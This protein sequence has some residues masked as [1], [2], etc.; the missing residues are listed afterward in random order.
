MQVIRRFND[1]YFPIPAALICGVVIL[2]TVNA[3][4][5]TLSDK[6]KRYDEQ[7]TSLEMW[8]GEAIHV[9]VLLYIQAVRE[10]LSGDEDMS[11]IQR[12]HNSFQDRIAQLHLGSF[13]AIE[14]NDSEFAAAAAALTKAADDL[15]EI[16]LG[17]EVGSP[18]VLKKI[19]SVLSSQQLNTQKISNLSSS[20]YVEHDNEYYELTAE[21]NQYLTNN[22]WLS[23][24]GVLIIV[25]MFAFTVARSKNETQKLRRTITDIENV[26]AVSPNL[27]VAVAEDLSVKIAT[28]AAMETLCGPKHAAGDKQRRLADCFA[29]RE[30]VAQ[31]QSIV[32]DLLAPATETY[33]ECASF[34]MRDHKNQEFQ[35]EIYLERVLIDDEFY[36]AVF[37]RNIEPQLAAERELIKARDEALAADR[38]KSRFLR[39]ISHE[40]RTPMQALRSAIDILDSQR[41]RTIALKSARTATDQ[42]MRRFEN[43]IAIATGVKFELPIKEEL[44]TVKSIFDDVSREM[45]SQFIASDCA[46]SFQDKTGGLVYR[47]DRALVLQVLSNLVD[48]AMKHGQGR[49]VEVKADLHAQ[50]DSKRLEFSVTDYGLGI[51]PDHHSKIFEEF[52]SL[53]AE[54]DGPEGGVGLGLT[55]SRRIVKSI[56]DDILVDSKPG[57]GSRFSFGIQVESVLLRKRL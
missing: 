6:I 20:L 31:F 57:R 23:V 32:A 24:S 13:R 55:V 28:K 29:V 38:A 9:D 36:V 52:V 15:E 40:V 5:L 14:P 17:V 1:R 44:V 22:W 35:T 33:N 51:D 8:G 54:K 39:V 2:I 53:G 37:F 46:V 30:D 48:N 12:R 43:M 26:L 4:I 47:I 16:I 18:D 19:D 50:G 56:G 25:I 45:S 7:H 41:A 49:F 3:P 10:A 42:I 21:Y 27:W 11:L 34:P